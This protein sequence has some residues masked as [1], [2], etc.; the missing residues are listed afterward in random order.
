MKIQEVNVMGHRE[1]LWCDVRV[2]ANGI[3]RVTGKPVVIFSCTTDHN[4][5]EF[6]KGLKRLMADHTVEGWEL[7]CRIGSSNKDLI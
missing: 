4:R 1:P 7:S 2:E 3:D 5:R 6:L